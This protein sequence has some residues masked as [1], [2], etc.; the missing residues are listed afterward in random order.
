MEIGL[1]AL[2][3]SPTP[4]RAVSGDK[5]LRLHF[6]DKLAGHTSMKDVYM[7]IT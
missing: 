2:G 1:A 7:T 3:S 6:D 5:R 4:K